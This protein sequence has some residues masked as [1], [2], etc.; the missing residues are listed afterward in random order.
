[1]YQE[2]KDSIQITKADHRPLVGEVVLNLEQTPVQES[3]QADY[4]ALLQALQSL[5]HAE[6]TATIS[7]F[8]L[9]LLRNV[10]SAGALQG[11]ALAYT[12][13]EADN[14]LPENGTILLA[15]M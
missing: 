5:R 14:R 4:D 3:L 13:T 8:Q 15:L 12:I 2:T 9:E 10:V 6:D 1:M 7:K 11:S